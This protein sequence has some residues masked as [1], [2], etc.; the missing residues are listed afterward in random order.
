[1]ARARTSAGMS[2]GFRL[3]SSECT[4]TAVAHLDRRLHEVLVRA[5]HR[6]TRLECRHAR[7]AKPLE[8]RA[9]LRGRHEERAILGFESALGKDL[10]RTGEVVI[11]LAHDHGDAGCAASVVRNTAWHSRCLSIL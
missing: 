3:P 7:P 5:L 9:R 8:L 6:V 2:P 4:S 10:Y 1:M 11:A